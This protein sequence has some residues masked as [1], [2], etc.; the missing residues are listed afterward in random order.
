MIAFRKVSSLWID[1]MP[2]K[3]RLQLSGWCPNVVCK[4]RWGNFNVTD[5]E[6]HM[7]SFPKTMA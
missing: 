1:S 7:K 6:Y 3:I 4:R 5:D 2:H